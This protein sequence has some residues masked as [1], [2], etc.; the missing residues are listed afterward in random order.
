VTLPIVVVL[1]LLIGT[2]GGS[3]KS[4]KA[5]PA[6]TPSAPPSNAAAAAP[7]T[8]LLQNLPVRLEGLTPRTV[9]PVP[10]SPFVVAWGDPAVIVRCGVARPKDLHTGS[11]AQFQGFGAADGSD[12]VY[13]DVTSSGS[14]EIYTSVDRAVYVEITLPSKYPG[15][16]FVTD[17]AGAIAKAMPAVC[18]GGQPYG[19]A[20]PPTDQLCS[21][22]P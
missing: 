18:V 13:F 22:R 19:G 6:L 2:T 15:S 14:D 20:L 5:L 8:K 9:H 7:C 4:P 17:L 10:D 16:T 21:R 12:K 3:D 11:T 1:A